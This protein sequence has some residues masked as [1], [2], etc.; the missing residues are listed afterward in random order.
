MRKEHVGRSAEIR[1]MREVAHGIET[2]VLVHRRSEHMGGDARYHEGEPIG[3]RPRDCLGTEK[4]TAA[5]P[6]LDVERLAEGG[7]ERLGIEPPDRVGR[8]AP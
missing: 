8:A 6:V 4:S 2:D 5:D 1:D 7:A 3:L